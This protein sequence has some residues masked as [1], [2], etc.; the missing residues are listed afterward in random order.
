MAPATAVLLRFR[1]LLGDLEPVIAGVA[2]AVLLL[3]IWQFVLAVPDAFTKT[4]QIEGI[5]VA[6]WVRRGRRINPWGD[7]VPRH[8]YL[9]VDDGSA[10]RIRGWH[11][12]EHDF[13]SVRRGDIVVADIEHHLGYV[14]SL[15]TIEA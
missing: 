8:R 2:A 13:D 15:R 5:V 11:V 14:R 9:A 3:S 10:S 4:T 6:R 1:D 7:W 12:S